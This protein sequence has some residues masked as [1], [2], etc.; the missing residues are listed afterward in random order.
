[1]KYASIDSGHQPVKAVYELRDAAVQYGKAVAHLDAEPSFGARDE[2]LAKH[3]TL[4][5][6]T[7]AA[8][9]ECS[10][11]AEAAAHEALDRPASK[12]A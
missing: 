8:I 2:V 9:D 7:V 1:M 6:K 12:R 4:E 11:N 10:E 3:T 5:E